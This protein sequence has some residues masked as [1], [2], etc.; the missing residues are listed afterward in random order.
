MRDPPSEPLEGRP[1]DADAIRCLILAGGEVGRIH[2][3]GC[4]YLHP[5]DVDI[6][7]EMSTSRLTSIG[8]IS[9]SESSSR[10]AVRLL[11]ST[12]HPGMAGD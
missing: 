5:E 10:M 3:P 12:G 2:D 6:A 9:R 4:P 1:G 8:S 7:P 11:V